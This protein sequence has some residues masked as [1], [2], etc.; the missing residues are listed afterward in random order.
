MAT[1]EV[2]L[3]NLGLCRAASLVSR[4]IGEIAQILFDERAEFLGILFRLRLLQRGAIATGQAREGTASGRALARTVG[5]AGAVPVS[6]A[7]ALGIGLTAASLTLSTSLRSAL[8]FA[9]SLCFAFAFALTFSFS[10]ALAVHRGFGADT[11]LRERQRGLG[12]GERLGG[13]SRA[14]LRGRILVRRSLGA[15]L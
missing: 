9:L 12:L 13:G 8:S 10:F 6:T 15:A 5:A 2:G 4:L 3:P 11:S 1:L 7:I 14:L